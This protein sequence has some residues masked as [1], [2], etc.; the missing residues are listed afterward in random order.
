M[1][2]VSATYLARAGGEGKFFN[3]PA[4]ILF[5]ALYPGSEPFEVDRGSDAGSDRIERQ[6]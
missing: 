3:M 5:F 1:P 4:L 2:T 6:S